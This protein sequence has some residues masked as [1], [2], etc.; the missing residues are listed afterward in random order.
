[1]ALYIDRSPEVE[2]NVLS[3]EKIGDSTVHELNLILL[4]DL[5]LLVNEEFDKNWRADSDREASRGQIQLH[6][7]VAEDFE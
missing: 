3:E 4:P 5:S 1:M 2:L 7:G 6:V